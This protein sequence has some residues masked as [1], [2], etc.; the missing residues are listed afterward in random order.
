MAALRSPRARA[1]VVRTLELL[2]APRLHWETVTHPRLH[3][4]VD[5]R[6][7]SAFLAKPGGQL[8]AALAVGA[9][10]H[11]RRVLG[12]LIQVLHHRF[13]GMVHRSGDPTL[14]P[15]LVGSYVEGGR[16]TR[17]DHRASV[18]G[19]QGLFKAL[20]RHLI[21]SSLIQSATR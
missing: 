3:A 5:A 16:I 10:D 8:C 15:F 4:A 7:L 17:R 19:A 14:L 11:D 20:G 9:D 1:R 12:Q 6:R 2:G 21:L 18:L 13:L